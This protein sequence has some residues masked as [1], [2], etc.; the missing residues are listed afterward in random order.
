MLGNSCDNQTIGDGIISTG[1]IK[2]ALKIS[3]IELINTTKVTNSRL[4]VT[5][6]IQIPIA[7]E[8]IKNGNINVK[9]SPA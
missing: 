8:L 5:E 4:G 2:P 6:P 3:G 7:H 1:Q 9:S